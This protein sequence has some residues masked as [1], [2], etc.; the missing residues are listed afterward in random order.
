[1]NSTIILGS[2]HSNTAEYY[3]VLGLEQSTLVLT[4][5]QNFSVGHTSVQD[6]TDLV[7]LE[8]LL[9]KTNDVYWAFP[10]KNQF[11][12]DEYYYNFLY[13]LQEYNYRYR[14]VRNIDQIKLDPYGWK[15][16]APKLTPDDIVFLGSSTTAGAGLPDP[17]TWYSTKVAKYFNKRSMI[18]DLD[19]NRINFRNNDKNFEIFTQLD[20]VP[21]QI[22]VVQ[23]TPIDRIRWC[24]EDSVLE[25]LYLT[26]TSTPH[27][28]A[29][30]SVFNRKYLIYRLLNNLRAMIRIAR[31]Q[32]IR[33]V[34]WVDNYKLDKEFE[35]EQL[36]FYEYKEVIS[37]VRLADYFVDHATDHIHPGVN[38]NQ[39][40]ADQIIQHIE[41]LYQ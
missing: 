8:M 11:E 1:M 39:I 9:K 6:I 32:K 20:F 4:A 27:H 31:L 3:R 12:Q 24:D 38:A 36:Y 10:D 7:E 33:L 30:I 28:R 19:P 35:Q 40:L 41:R 15:F 2:N 21:G 29:M 13:W 22:V 18:N 17:D 5:D 37:K 34:L 14:N 26:S 23:I 25:D 16:N